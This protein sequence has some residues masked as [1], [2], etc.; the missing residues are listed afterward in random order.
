MLNYIKLNLPFELCF[1]CYIYIIYI[2][3]TGKLTKKSF[4]VKLASTLVVSRNDLNKIL[5]ELS[6]RIYYQDIFHYDL[7]IIALNYLFEK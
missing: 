6:L 4:S 5:Q 1:I 3:H 2:L 7:I